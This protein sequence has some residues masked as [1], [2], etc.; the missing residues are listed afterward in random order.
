MGG[1]GGGI[2]SMLIT[3]FKFRARESVCVANGERMAYRERVCE[4]GA[5]GGDDTLREN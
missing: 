2:N 4:S 1:G 5:G 3:G